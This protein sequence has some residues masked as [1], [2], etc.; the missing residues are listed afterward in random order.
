MEV[1]QNYFQGQGFEM[2]ERRRKPSWQVEQDILFSTDTATVLRAVELDC[3][4]ILMARAVDGVYDSDPKDNPSA[5]KYDQISME[6]VLDKK[7][8]VIDL[9]A[10]VLS[11]EN[12]MPILLFGLSQEES[13]VKA[14][15]GDSKGTI[16]EA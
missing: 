16:I 1:C 15:R 14:A 2:H 11:I 6:T 7:L 9:T 12:K 5:K 10:S 13:I 3:D 8:G 4:I